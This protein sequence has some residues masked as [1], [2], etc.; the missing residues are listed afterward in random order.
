M[1]PDAEHQ[2]FRVGGF[3]ELITL[4]APVIGARLGVMAM[5]LTDAIVVGRY[6]AQQL[7]FHALG[8]APTGVVLISAAG[9]L[10][11]VQVMTSRAIGEGRLHETGA[12]LRRGVIYA[13]W[14]GLIAAL[15]LFLLGEPLL[16]ALGLEPT[17]VRGAGGVLRVFALSLPLFMVA[18]AASSYL[19]GLARPNAALIAMW[20]AN[21]VN[22]GVDLVL[23]PGGFGLPALGAQG[24]AWS[25]FFARLVLMAALLIYIARM[26]D[27]RA[28]GVFDRPVRNRAAEAE[29][30]R[31]GFGGGAALFAESAGFSGMNI[32]AGW[33]GGLTVAG[34]AVVLNVTS[35]VFMVPM[36]LGAATAVLVGRAYGARDPE[37]LRRVGRMGFAI[38][39]VTGLAISLIVWPLSRLVAS[40]YATDPTL[41]ALASTGIAIVS[42]AFVPDGL[43]VVAGMALRARGDLW[44]PTAVQIASYLLVML[45]LSWLLAIHFRIGLNGICLAMVAASFVS[46]TLLVARFWTLSRRA[47]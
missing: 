37:A 15:G 8:W 44:T 24:A 41:L 27:A 22:L 35:V 38:Y 40:G 42:I 7:G 1:Q 46:A 26:P 45:P 4:A 14:I 16:G 5:G 34:W 30:R 20:A 2:P 11:G 9:L 21:I 47:L 33:A 29:Q 43:Q 3:Y 25:T 23:V 10:T 6:S 18:S 32:V 39:A 36:G 12:V 19:E 17:L 13:L 28:L 31:I